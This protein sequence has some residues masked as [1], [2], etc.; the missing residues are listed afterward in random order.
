M[1][2]AFQSYSPW[3]HKVLELCFC[4][5]MSFYNPGKG[6]EVWK[7]CKLR[8]VK[9]SVTHQTWIFRYANVRLLFHDY[10]I[11]G[12]TQGPIRYNYFAVTISWSVCHC[13]YLSHV[14][15]VFQRQT[16][17][18]IMSE[19]QWCWKENLYKTEQ[20]QKN[21]HLIKGSLTCPVFQHI[22]R[23]P[24]PV[25]RGHIFSC[26]RPSYE[27]AVSDLDRPMNISLWVQVA[28]SSFIELSQ[29]TKN[30]ASEITQD[31]DLTL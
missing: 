12:W 8:H 9:E 2:S 19:H 7:N 13:F 14:P 23:V 31:S 27:W 22:F 25:S 17:K 20:K 1:C 26:V 28:H 5:L 6:F 24:C 16:F 15:Q 11:F 29:T 10:T 30:T 21:L 18:I 3:L 4:A